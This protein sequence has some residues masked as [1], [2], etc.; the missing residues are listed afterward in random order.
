[1]TLDSVNSALLVAFGADKHGQMSNNAFNT[2]AQRDV[3]SQK[4]DKEAKDV[5]NSIRPSPINTN[6]V[7]DGNLQALTA[8]TASSSVFSPSVRTGSSV[9]FTPATSTYSPSIWSD[10][11]GTPMSISETPENTTPSAKTVQDAAACDAKHAAGAVPDTPSKV[12]SSNKPAVEDLASLPPHHLIKGEPGQRYALAFYDENGVFLPHRF[13]LT[14]DSNGQYHDADGQPCRFPR[15]CDTIPIQYVSPITSG[16]DAEPPQGA[17]I[18]KHDDF[19]G[20]H[21]VVASTYQVNDEEVEPFIE[22]YLKSD[23]TPHFTTTHPHLAGKKPSVFSEES[24]GGS[25]KVQLNNR[26]LPILE[27]FPGAI[28]LIKSLNPSHIQMD[29]DA[30]AS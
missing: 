27:A 5:V 20:S 15:K 23:I 10:G 26:S 11:A 29:L 14:R 18:D 17:S 3:G 6:I 24:A 19:E 7:K 12:P 1:M 21:T 9:Q 25:F 30:S 4:Q 13:P 8:T 16:Q 28:D 22:T 2:G